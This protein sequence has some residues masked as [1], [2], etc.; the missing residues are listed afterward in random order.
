M[1]RVQ[2]ACWLAGALVATA[3][4]KT[5]ALW[6]LEENLRCL[7]DT[8]L[9]L[10]TN[11][12]TRLSEENA[13]PWA[14]PPNPDTDRHLGELPNSKAIW[15]TANSAGPM[16]TVTDRDL[17]NAVCSTSDFTIE[18]WINVQQIP[19]NNGWYIL[20]NAL[21]GSGGP[22][23]WIWSMRR[24]SRSQYFTDFELFVKD[25][26]GDTCLGG[27]R[28]EEPETQLV[29]QWMHVALTHV[30]KNTDGKSEWN[31]YTNGVFYAQ[32]VHNA[33]AKQTPSNCALEFGGRSGNVQRFR[34]GLD[35]WRVSDRVLAPEEFLCAGGEGSPMPVDETPT[36]FYWKLDRKADGTVD[37]TPQVG[38]TALGG[39]Y[40]V[41]GV[42]SPFRHIGSSD[43][44]F[45]GQ[46]PNTTVTL[47]RDNAGCF[48]APEGSNYLRFDNLGRELEIDRAFTVEGWFKPERTSAGSQNVQYIFNTRTDGNGWALGLQSSNTGD[49][50]YL[51]LYAQQV[52]ASKHIL[53]GNANLSPAMTDWSDWKHVALT[54]D[55]AAG[56]GRGVW[57]CYLDGVLSGSATNNQV[58]TANS[59][60]EYFHIGGRVGTATTFNGYIDCVRVARGVLDPRQFLCEANDPLAVADADVLGLWP[61]DS[62]RGVYPFSEDVKGTYPI[63]ALSVWDEKYLVG[64]VE[65]APVITN[66]D[67][68]EA[69]AGSPTNLVGAA[70]FNVPANNNAARSHLLTY[71]TNVC[72]FFRNTRPGWT[73]ECFVKRTSGTPTNWELIFG[74]CNNMKVDATGMYINFTYRNNGF[75]MFDNGVCATTNGDEVFPDSTGS[76]LPVGAWAHVALEFCIREIDGV[77]KGVYEVFVNGVSKG[78]IVKDKINPSANAK[79]FT[80]GGRLNSDSSFKGAISSLR[81]SRRALD[82][83][84]FLCAAGTSAPQTTG[85]VAYWPLDFD[86]TSVD[87]GSRVQTGAWITERVGV[88]G[89]AEM[90]LPRVPNGDTSADFVGDP[91]ANN[92]S[93]V[94]SGA[95]CRLVVPFLGLRADTAKAFTF[96]GWMKWTGAASASGHDI[97]MGTYRPSFEKGWKLYIDSTGGP[98]CLRLFAKVGYPYS[99][100]VPDRVL[101]ADV[102]DWRNAWKHL[103]FVYDPHAGAKGTWT[104]WVDGK[105]AGCVE[106][107]WSPQGVVA[108]T[109]LLGLGMIPHGLSYAYDSATGGYDMWRLSEGALTKDD[110]LYR[111]PNSTLLIIR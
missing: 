7:V 111:R 85:T 11:G 22:G 32:L 29:D 12:Y 66:P 63:Q 76:D 50:W 46:P 61:L 8:R 31:M 69:F 75:Y 53:V 67:S 23:G 109:D 5:V 80:L 41:S 107:L 45:E 95:S 71:S 58:P 110:F 9:Q 81:L 20:V 17:A 92:G 24:Q 48:Y 77:E 16:A 47:P 36:A 1:K 68:T 25:G 37:T 65:D 15:S 19:D 52:D 3:Q 73:A 64:T 54:Y 93:V 70:A 39:G 59:G 83:S 10:T 86:G 30:W 56:D 2:V 87:F 108:G 34:G 40:V 44:A 49:I 51:Q 90:A 102:S 89:S 27:K 88:A 43:R 13:L 62:V 18:G 57:S 60:S 79:V 100:L 94:L 82:P 4:A 98:P 99:P 28:F 103:A 74:L 84:E 101:V 14:I 38:R 106:N 97:V 35:Y 72:S 104:L 26:P 21:G 96:E 33:A 91:R 105:V 55:P 42:D 78:R 6:P